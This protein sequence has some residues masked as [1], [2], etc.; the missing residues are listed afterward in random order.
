[1][2]TTFMLFLELLYEIGLLDIFDVVMMRLA[3][4][5]IR[6]KFRRFKWS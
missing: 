6:K 1:M 3:Y 2:A 5:N 4:S